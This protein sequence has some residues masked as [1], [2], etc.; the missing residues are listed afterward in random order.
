MWGTQSTPGGDWS[1]RLT[2]V[3][4]S[5]SEA[6]WVD[7]NPCTGWPTSEWGQDGVARGYGVLRV[8]PFFA[9][10]VYTVT[11]G[12][13]D[14]V[15]GARVGRSLSVGQVQVQ[16]VERVFERPE[17]GVPVEALFGDTLRLLGYDLQRA[18]EEVEL[19]LHWQATRRMG[20]AY[21][22][23]VHLFDA[24]TGEMVAQAD[25]MPRNWGYPTTW[26]EKGE[27]VSDEIA[28]VVSDVPPGT[29]DVMIGAYDPETG[30]RLPVVDTTHVS[31]AEDRLLLPERLALP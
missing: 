5:G 16:A 2:L 21:K 20:V 18:G 4:P 28:L 8:D 7:F 26:W 22:F 25:V 14:P 12:L 30:V 6:Q 19:T 13:L 27:Y 15:T 31:Q 11:V 10:G 17:I 3:S 9:D 1:A 24:E 23:F 29:Y